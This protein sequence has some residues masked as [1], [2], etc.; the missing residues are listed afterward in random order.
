MHHPAPSQSLIHPLSK[1]LRCLVIYPGP[2]PPNCPLAR[3]S[4]LPNRT[5]CDP[6]SSDGDTGVE[7]TLVTAFDKFGAKRCVFSSASDRPG[8]QL[9]APRYPHGLYERPKPQGPFIV[10]TLRCGDYWCGQFCRCT[11]HVR[12]HLTQGLRY[13]AHKCANAQSSKTRRTSPCLTT[14]RTPRRPGRR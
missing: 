7:D 8:P 9:T 2:G 5:Y 11:R 4:P 14:V 3:N 1:S 6:N 10:P 12:Y 13:R